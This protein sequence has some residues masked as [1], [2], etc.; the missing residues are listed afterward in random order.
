MIERNKPDANPQ[1]EIEMRHEPLVLKCIDFRTSEDTITWLESQGIK[2]G[3]YHLY[4][5]AGASGNPEGFVQTVQAEQPASTFVADH[6]DCGF[7][8]KNGGDSPEKHHHNLEI[9][10]N[11]LHDG[12]PD[13]NYTY[14]LVPVNDDRHTCTAAAIILGE[15]DLVKMARDNLREQGLA[16]D[17]DEIARPYELR[18]D[19]ETIWN[20]LD[21]SLTLHHPSKIFLFEKDEANAHRLIEKIKQVAEGVHV[22]PV[23][24]QQTA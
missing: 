5:S 18:V 13:I 2:E 22:E 10:G 12:N 4:A 24:L 15:P 21:I 16:N 7:Y 19:D 3:T 11:T 14:H 9:L 20:D 6:E 8:K 1:T 17:Y 23:I